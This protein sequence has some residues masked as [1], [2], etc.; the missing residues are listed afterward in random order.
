MGVKS[1]GGVAGRVTG[2]GAAMAVVVGM[3]T[4]CGDVAAVSNPGTAGN[5]TGGSGGSGA[6]GG[7]ESGGSGGTSGATSTGG[8]GGGVPQGCVSAR[9]YAPGIEECDGEFV[10]RKAMAAC[11]L[12]ERIEDS[13]SGGE[14]GAPFNVLCDGDDDCTERAN[15]YCIRSNHVPLSRVDCVYGCETDDDCGASE[16]C[17]CGTRE[18]AST[19]AM[20]TLGQCVKSSCATDDDC[21][22]GALCIATLSRG[23]GYSWPGSFNCETPADECRGGDDCGLAGFCYYFTDRFECAVC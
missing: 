23:C 10:H 11:P 7:D 14:G 18:H 12:P 6:E 15:G 21:S 17:S 16:V 1:W 8:S 22:G 13:G 4:A 9:Y 5:G 20:V 2:I 3:F 19:A